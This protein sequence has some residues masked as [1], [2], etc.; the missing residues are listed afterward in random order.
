MSIL[1]RD[2][3]PKSPAPNKLRALNET[4][5]SPGATSRSQVPQAPPPPPPP[6]GADKT[7]IKL[8]SR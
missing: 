4:R 7:G 5:V 1:D 6:K 8:K 2:R 3:E